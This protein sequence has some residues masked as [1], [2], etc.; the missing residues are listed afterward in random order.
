MNQKDFLLQSSH[1]QNNNVVPPINQNI[2][3]TQPPISQPSKNIKPKKRGIGIIVMLMAIA[4]ILIGIGL[5]FPTSE[6]SKVNQDLFTYSGIYKNENAEI[7]I[8]ASHTNLIE[9]TIVDESGSYTVA[10]LKINKNKL[11]TDTEFFDEKYS[12]TV[13]KTADGIKVT[14]N[15]NNSESI[16]NKINGS[17]TK[18]S[19]TYKGWTGLYNLDD[20]EIIIDEYGENNAS[21][22][23]LQNGAIHELSATNITDRT[24][25]FQSEFD[26][27]S[28][29]KIE[30][31][32]DGITVSASDSDPESLLN[33]INGTYQ[34]TK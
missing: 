21:I 19:F 31:T 4:F 5:Q 13:E 1:N 14:A 29:L 25:S 24:I 18:Q 2:V 9:A 7:R 10:Y 34:K 12:I 11:Y 28:I 3:D 32:I 30:K 17:Y 27:A 23:I 26:E 8:H 6:T 33:K 16:Y 22:T 15:S 20:I